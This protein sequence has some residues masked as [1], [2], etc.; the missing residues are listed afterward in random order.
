MGHA[1]TPRTQLESL[2]KEAKRWLKAVRAG[3]AKALARLQ[4]AWPEAPA[5]PTLRD[6]QPALARD[7]GHESWVALKAALDDLAMDRRGEAERAE[8]VLRHGWGGEARLARRILVC[9]LV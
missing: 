8:I 4:A 6:M 5:E 2:R 9:C 3:D 1:L 7:Y